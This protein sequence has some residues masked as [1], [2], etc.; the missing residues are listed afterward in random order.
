MV[1]GLLTNQLFKSE[2][3]N[4]NIIDKIINMYKQKYNY[5]HNIYITLKS[6]LI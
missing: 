2:D 4:N 5:Y 3:S 1:G 6:N